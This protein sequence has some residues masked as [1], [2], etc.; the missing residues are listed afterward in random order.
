MIMVLYGTIKVI[1]SQF[2]DPTLDRLLQ[3]FGDAS[4]MGMLWTFM[5]LSEGYNVFSGTGEMLGGLLLTTRRTTL[6]GALVNI[7]VVSHVVALNFCYDVPVKLFSLN[8]LAMALFLA[9]PDAR[10]LANLFLWNRAV[11]AAE[12]RPLTCRR[13]LNVTLVVVRSLLVLGFTGLHLYNANETRKLFGSGSERSPLYGIWSV[14]EL[15]EDGIDRPPRMTDEKR[16]RRVV[17]DRPGM[18]A[19]QLMND[20]RSRF[21]VELDPATNTLKLFKRLTGEVYA[22]L[23]Y[24]RPESERLILEGTLEGHTIRAALRRN[25]APEFLLVTRGFHWINEYPFNR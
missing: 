7:G 19:V 23:T 15:T 12:I 2:P 5:G 22:Q 1:K 6:L 11:P 18:V 10:R 17:F 24:Q 9:A 16:W 21:G 14:D 8:L 25:E 3:P 13:W 20:N 4:P